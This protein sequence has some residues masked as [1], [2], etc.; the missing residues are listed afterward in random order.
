MGYY[1]E[2]TLTILKN[3]AS[4][5]FQTKTNLW[6]AWTTTT[7]EKAI[8]NQC[9]IKKGARD[10]LSHHPTAQSQLLP[11]S[12]NHARPKLLHDLMMAHAPLPPT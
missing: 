3:R 9:A 5:H 7:N 10:R 2:T 4:C 6:L 1:I 12:P 8:V 11:E